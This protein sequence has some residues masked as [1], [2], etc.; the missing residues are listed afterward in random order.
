M[1]NRI[2]IDIQER[3]AFADGHAF[4]EAGAYERL[5]GRAR[6]AV[7]PDAPAQAGIVDVDKAPRNGDGLVEFAAD[8]C[9]LKPVDPARAN[10][11]LFF[12]YGNRGNK[13]AV[14]YF[15]D[16]PA[17]ND[18]ATLA[19]A[20]N[21]YLFRRGYTVVWGAW[22]GDLLPGDG[23]MILTL[24]VARDGAQP[25]TGMVRSEFIVAQEGQ[26]T[27]PLSG[28]VSTRSHPAVSR[29]PSKAR[30]TRRRYPVDERVEITPDAWRFARVETGMGLDFQGAEQ[31]I[32]E[33][34]THICMSGGF[35]PGW[36]YELVYEGRD[37]LVLGLGY[38]AVRDLVSFL[39][40]EDS[41]SEGR[42]NPVADGGPME[43]AYAFGRSQ[44][45]RLI[46]DAIYRGFNADAAGRKVFD[47]V[48]AHVAGCGRMWMNHRFANV[49][50]PAGQQYED[51]DNYADSFPFSYAE[52]T[53]HLTGRSDAICK[54]PETDPLIFHSQ[55]AT[56]YWQRRGSLV[57]T[58]TEGNDL[59]Q[60]DNV[61]VYFWSSAPHVADPNQGAPVRGL[62][63][64]LSNVVQ[65]SIL[66]RALLDAM[67]RWASDGIAPP[68]SRIPRRDDGSLVGMDQWRAQFPVIPGVATP[69][70]PNALPLFDF[71][72]GAANGIQGTLPPAVI[73][74]D[75]YTVLV[76]AVDIDGNDIAGV[77]VP[78]VE[79]PLATYTGWNLRSRGHGEGAMHEFTGSTIPLPETESIRAATGDP[80]P[81]IEQRY[82]DADAYVAAIVRAAE[83]LVAEGLMLEEDI[84]RVE[85]R[86]RDWS[87][88]LHDV[89]L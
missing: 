21:G 66:F 73:E 75:G 58:D 43:R 74:P 85:Q 61:R 64:H 63:Q 87:R 5:I 27:L 65:T 79:A 14:Q 15:N 22:Q 67:D 89:R 47:G 25:L 24:P 59:E 44:T 29:D 48:L 41:D 70:G 10:R 16:A 68:P 4:A 88:P 12:D 50:V 26:T 42:A 32:V 30:L 83:R 78:M 71:G 69:R 33:S 20:G 60:P 56:E 46:R 31:A 76:P 39:K 84:A 8:L 19:H 7:D 77:R 82:G 6:F 49:V 11:R 3:T 36:I 38:V 13:R 62:C 17:C 45:G 52:C 57:H 2:T 80:R 81:S 54:R 55:S 72:P 35:E 9:I 86:A 53:D 23:R 37:P 1:S 34:D 40:Y 28:W 18:P 51:H